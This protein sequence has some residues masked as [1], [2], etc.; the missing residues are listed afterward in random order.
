MQLS[1]RV[2]S[3]PLPSHFQATHL[4]FSCPLCLLLLL[5]H[6]HHILALMPQCSQKMLVQVC[7]A[8]YDGRWG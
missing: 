8:G 3:T 4:L 1:S 5:H 6:L 7:A 2:Y